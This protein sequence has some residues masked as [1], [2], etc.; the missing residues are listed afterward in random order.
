MGTTTG[1]PYRSIAYFD[2]AQ[3]KTHEIQRIGEPSRST[4]FLSVSPDEK[5]YLCLV[6]E[7]TGVDIMVVDNFR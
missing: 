5:R 2:F 6:D 4:S 3:S 7:G 1:S